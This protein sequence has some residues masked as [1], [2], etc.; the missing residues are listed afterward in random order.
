MNKKTVFFVAF[1]LIFLSLGI[2]W[3]FL[4]SGYFPTDDGEWAVV[5]LAEMHRELKDLQLPPRWSGFLNHGFGYPLFLFTYPLPYYLGEIFNL[6]NFGLVN[7]IKI[8][9]IL[10]V[11]LSGLTMFL[12]G[13]KLWGKWAGLVSALFYLYLPWRLVDLYVRGSIGES[14]AFVFYPLLFWLA[15]NLTEKKNSLWIASTSLALAGLILTHNVMA[16]LFM[17]FWLAFMGLLLWQKKELAVLSHFIS[18]ILLGFSLSAF[19]WLPAIVEKQSVVVGKMPIANI[20]ENFVKPLQLIMPSGGFSFQI[21]WVHLLGFFLGLLSLRKQRVVGLFFLL[22]F[23]TLIILMLAPSYPFWH[24]LPLFSTVDFPWRL[25][26]V[27][28]FLVS[29]GAGAMVLSSWGKKIAVVL[30]VLVIL[31]NLGYAKPASTFNK[32]DE[33]YRTNDATTTSFDELMPVWV[34]DKPKNKPREKV[35]GLYSKAEVKLAGLVFDSKKISFL[36]EINQTTKVR[37][38]AIYF[39]GWEAFIDG[40]QEPI[41]YDNPQGLITLTVPKGEHSI[42]L[43]WKN[44]PVRKISELISLAALITMILFISRFKYRRTG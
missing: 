11:L 6:L 35:S 41:E 8:V 38:N 10:S 32:G 22:S 31:F 43:D 14:L 2:I 17:P 4:K 20:W 34:K 33:Y 28:G 39:P 1:C 7:S 3:P 23:L 15:I 42:N 16:L 18:A 13:S 12:L 21:G 26:G 37:V 24:Y 25:L 36:A 5:R 29:L 30:A 19:F 44:T 40:N 9:F 27:M